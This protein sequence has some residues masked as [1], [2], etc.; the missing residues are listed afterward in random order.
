M[1]RM[2]AAMQSTITKSKIVKIPL[3]LTSILLVATVLVPQF[4]N[5]D[6]LSPQLESILHSSVGRDVPIGR[7]Q[8]SFLAGGIRAENVS[9]ADDPAFSTGTFVESKSLG[10]GLSLKPD[11]PGVFPHPPPDLFNP[12]RTPCKPRE[13]CFRQ[14][15]LL[16]RRR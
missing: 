14:V 1:D 8:L 7:I 5:L 3:A 13:I 16:H 11:R 2:R 15:E 4:V 10:I 12:G 6:R 9:V